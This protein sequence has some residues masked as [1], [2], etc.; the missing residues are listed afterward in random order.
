[1]RLVLVGQAA[2]AQRVL[3]GVV[4]SGHEIAAVFAPPARGD[5]PDPLAVEGE[6]LGIPV[7]T[8]ASY[9]EAKVAAQFRELGADLGLLAYVTRIIPPD[10]IDAPR[11]GTLCF[12]PSLL[13][14]YRGGSALA[15]QLIRGERRGGFT[16]FWTDPGIDT[17]PILLQREVEIGPDDT[18]GSLYFEKILEPGAAAMVEAVDLVATGR[19]PR[20]AQD[21]ARASYDP[22][23]TDAHAAI[24]WERPCSEVYDLVRGCDPQPGAHATFDDEILRFFDARRAP[25]HV[26]PGTKPGT[27][28]EIGDAGLV[29]AVGAGERGGALLVG[30]LRAGGAKARAS[31]VAAAIH[32]RPGAVLGDGRA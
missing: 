32:M 24:A 18:A 1:M 23:C 6:R 9:R 7:H 11:L 13:P 2:F 30:R 8:P 5:R 26:P 12:H 27:V 22:L 28:L 17:G 29:V 16:I 14:R 15:W 21:E 31:E 25:D 4:A 3:A 19:A 10:V 20:V